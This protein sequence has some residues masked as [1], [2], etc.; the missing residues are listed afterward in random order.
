MTKSPKI[1]LIAVFVAALLP[2]AAT[3]R[4]NPFAAEALVLSPPP[5]AA[6]PGHWAYAASYGYMWVPDATLG[7]CE[8]EWAPWDPWWV[9]PYGQ[10]AWAD[11]VGW[12]WTPAI[13]PSAMSPLGWGWDGWYGGWYGFLPNGWPSNTFGGWGLAGSTYGDRERAIAWT[14]R[15]GPHKWDGPLGVKVV[16]VVAKPPA[17]IAA[18][19]P[20]RDTKHRIDSDQGRPGYEPPAGR[21]HPRHRQDRT[22]PARSHGGRTNNGRGGGSHVG[23]YPTGAGQGGGIYVNPRSGGSGGGGGKHRH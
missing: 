6:P 7:T 19:R 1:A 16:A 11:G 10:W 15:H 14:N 9:M 18:I 20:M 12:G 13:P 22:E 2:L 5:S 8:A 17:S 21:R 4:G 3:A 23:S